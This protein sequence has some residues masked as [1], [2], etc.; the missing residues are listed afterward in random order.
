MTADLGTTPTHADPPGAAERRGCDATAG[1]R[2]T[3]HLRTIRRVRPS[4]V[5]VTALEVTA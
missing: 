1:D 2:M 5:T 4:G 3:A